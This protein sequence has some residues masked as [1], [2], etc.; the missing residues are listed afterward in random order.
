MSWDFV[1]RRNF[2]RVKIPCEITLFQPR[3]RT[4]SCHTENLSAG[5]IRVMIAERIGISSTIDL[6]IHLPDQRP[7]LCKGK[8]IWSFARKSEESPGSLFFDTGIEFS[9]IISKDIEAI[10]DFIL[11]LAR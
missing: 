6:S 5:G 11:A 9:A 7:I 3:D 4:L 2:V 10:K 8:V 1:E